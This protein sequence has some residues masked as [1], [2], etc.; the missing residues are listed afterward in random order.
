MYEFKI[1]EVDEFGNIKFIDD[2]FKNIFDRYS[3]LGECKT[4]DIE[5]PDDYEKVD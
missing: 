4:F 5:N 2:K 3:F 1:A